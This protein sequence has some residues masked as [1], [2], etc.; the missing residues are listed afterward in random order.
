MSLLPSERDAILVVD[1][2]AVPSGLIAPQRL[3]ST[4]GWNR[5]IFQSRRDIDR[6]K[7]PLRDT[8]VPAG[9]RESERSRQRL[10][11]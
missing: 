2:N 3:E 4:T 10:S 6:F 11:R 8:M 7:L 9:P 5:E 1:P